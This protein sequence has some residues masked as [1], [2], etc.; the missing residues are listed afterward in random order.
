MLVRG[1]TPTHKFT[2]PFDT[3]IV[4]TVKVL[5]AQD[6]IVV[7]EKEGEACN[8]SGNTVTVK[9]TQE[10]TFKFDCNKFVQIQVRVITQDDNSLVSEVKCVSVAKCLED[11]VL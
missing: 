6:D 2:L 9:L 3:G 10:D 4:K 8:C 11:E 5:Y 7:L 1:T